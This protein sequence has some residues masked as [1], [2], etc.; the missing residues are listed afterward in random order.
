M[1]SNKWM[2]LISVA[3]L[4]CSSARQP[5]EAPTRGTRAESPDGIRYVEPAAPSG[6]DT[7]DAVR[8]LWAKR[9]GQREARAEALRQRLAQEPMFKKVALETLEARGFEFFFTTAEGP[10]TALSVLIEA[11]KALPDHGKS[12]DAYPLAVLQ[13]DLDRLSAAASADKAARA[14]LDAMPAWQTLGGLVS[15]KDEP[16][17]AEINGLADAGR[18]KDINA[19]AVARMSERAAPLIDK[20]SDRIQMRAAIEITA[21]VAF[22]RYAL[23]MKYLII[24]HPFKADRSPAKADIP[25]AAELKQAFEAF[26]ANPKNGLVALIPT[27][28]NYAKTVAGLAFYRKIA[29][30]GGFSKLTYS[31]K[32]KRG[33]KGPAVAALKQRLA[34]EEY[35]LGPQ[36]STFDQDLEDAFKLY[37]DTH[38]FNVTGVLEERH[39]KSLNTT[40]EQRIRQIELSLQRWRESEV[41]PEEPIYVRVNIPEFKMEVWDNGTLLM[42]HK[43]VTGNNNWDKDP[44]KRLEGRINRTKLFSAKI[45]LMLLNPK[46]H[47][48]GRILK[49]EID[50]ELLK[51]PD[52]LVRH[53]FKVKV[54]PDGR[55]EVYQDSGGG[56]ALG[57]VKFTFPNP[58]GIFM[59]D[60]AQKPFFENEIRAFSHGCIRLH[61]P[62]E[63]A[64]FVLERSA[65]MTKEQVDALLDAGAQK[66]INLKTPIPIFVEY[67]SVG[68]DEK[69][70]MQFFSDAYGYDKDFF[71]GKIPYADDELRLL[72]RQI[73]RAD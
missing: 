72:T 16:T 54:L 29:T 25:H 60:T 3:L 53:N 19:K 22:F 48:P 23:D 12:L 10:S 73:P 64:Y 38:G 18:L 8:G 34:Q 13:T 50:Y 20:E 52:Y 66:E 69:G 9:A 14:E 57:K 30:N 5:I 44:A 33:S 35:F 40:V 32:L 70:R 17:L 4:S 56:N 68:V 21:S 1:R 6:N 63:V 51:E 2:F 42:K 11:I 24:A 15:G 39:V 41:K 27:H 55:E 49:Q 45:Q 26:A 47:V 59:H 67:N 46:W 58:Y 65:G 7:F 71:D 62:L 36:D 37:Q 61:D 43:V 28:P 31:G